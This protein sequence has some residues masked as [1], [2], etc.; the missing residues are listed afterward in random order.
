[1]NLHLFIFIFL[2]NLLFSKQEYYSYDME[3]P[4]GNSELKILNIKSDDICEEWIPSLSSPILIAPSNIDATDKKKID[5]LT[6]NNPFLNFEEPQLDITL[7]NYY[8]LNQ[9]FNATL[10]KIKNSQELKN[11]HLGLSSRFGTNTNINEKFFFLNILK[12]NKN[13]NKSI[14]SFDKWKLN[15]KTNTIKTNFYLGD[16]HSDFKE[17]KEKGI[18][19]TCQTNKS[20]PYMG[21]FFKQMSFNGKTA[22]LKNDTF[23]YKIYFSTDD[24]PI[25][26]PKS[27][28]NDF[29]EI[30][31]YQC[32][33]KNPHRD[34]PDY[35]LFCDKMFNESNFALLNL[36]NDDMNITIEIDN[37]VRFNIENENNLKHK[38]KIRYENV[39]YFIL[40]LIM[41]KNFHVQFDAENNIIQFYTT[42]K[43]ILSVK[44][45]EKT[46]KKGFSKVLLAFIIIIIILAISVVGFIIY[47]FIRMK[48]E[49]GIQKDIK[50][51]EDIEEFQSMN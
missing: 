42:N 44:N 32:F 1:M 10:G 47:K 46:K 2:I 13:L 6:I 45:E 48:K 51:I 40:P 35:Y 15:E 26:F 37:E 17:N 31:G 30:T 24:Y 5:E 49:E 21:C 4:T 50:K 27:F 7:Y 36:I 3:I 22:N 33:S 20:D 19:A 39:E 8:V 34:N 14:Y 41:F 11:C 28:E 9:K 12:E 38:T 16:S 25:L 23:I 18:I 29:N 43:S